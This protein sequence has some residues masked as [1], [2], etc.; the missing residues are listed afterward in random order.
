MSNSNETDATLLLL[1][2][3]VEELEAEFNARVAAAEI[4]A[5]GLEHQVHYLQQR[6]E[7][8]KN[9]NKTHRSEVRKLKKRVTE[10]EYGLQQSENTNIARDTES[11][12]SDN[13]V[14]TD[15]LAV[16]QHKAVDNNKITFGRKRK[17]QSTE[18][19]QK[20]EKSTRL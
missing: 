7:H 9:V 10:L 13:L 4:L 3:R 5:T 12:D 1:K 20:E 15:N 18:K 6:I 11:D 2:N 16:V 14:Y 19:S 17:C 8:E